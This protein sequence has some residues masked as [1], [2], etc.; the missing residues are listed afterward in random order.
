MRPDG[1]PFVINRNRTRR[2]NRCVGNKRAT[3]ESGS[4]PAL[5]QQFSVWFRS[6]PFRLGRCANVILRIYSSIIG[7]LKS[8]PNG[9]LLYFKRCVNRLIFLFCNDANKVA[10]HFNMDD[11][12]QY[13]NCV[14]IELD[15]MG[16]DISWP[17]YASVQ[18]IR[19]YEIMQ[20]VRVPTYYGV[21]LTAPFRSVITSF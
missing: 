5:F 3:I 19:P 14:N 12:G 17:N 10:I 6:Y 15:Q 7:L 13:C 8:L 18:H 20:K 2:T 11:T 21:N 16:Q 9:Y 1:Q 4:G